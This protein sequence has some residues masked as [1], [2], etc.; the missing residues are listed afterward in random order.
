MHIVETGFISRAEPH[1]NR[2]CLTF[3]TLTPLSDG[4]LMATARA[5]NDKDSDHEL[6]EFY[7]SDD[8]GATW[9]APAT[10][11]R[12]VNVHGRS[13]TL[14]LCYLTELAPDHL[15]A[16]AM[17]VDRTAHPGKPLFNAKTEGCL[18]M[19]ILLATSHDQGRTWTGWRSVDMPDEIGPP[20]LTNPI[21]R[22]ADGSLAMSIETNK[23]YDDASKWKQ[24][25]VFLRSDDLGQT[26]SEP[27]SVAEDPAARIFNWD[28]RCGVG[29]D[30]RI[31]SFAWTYDTKT[32]KYLNIHRRISADNGRTWTPA[33]D[34]GFAD[35]AGPPAMLADGR[36][37]LAWVDRF[38]DRCIRARL[39]SAIDA[40]FDPASEV[41]I[42]QHPH[43]PE[44][45]ARDMGDLLAG[46]ELW[47][48]GLPFATVLGNGEIL[49]TYYANDS[50]DTGTMSA[51][52]ARLKL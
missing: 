9:G 37:V 46:M 39:A 17:W 30:G 41:I 19:A 34:L 28:L 49:V 14:K 29:P 8:H 23:P 36:V 5:G 27:V 38:G 32:E 45:D 18:P 3:S 15:L 40:P 13:G 33:A 22:L 43:P 44:T 50:G 21:L 25:A 11:F 20:S 24:K 7:R 12:N 35:Q 51:R 42:Y 6:I 31:A 48:F 26:W 52:W 4:T 1:T 16:A 47:G 10:P 2:A